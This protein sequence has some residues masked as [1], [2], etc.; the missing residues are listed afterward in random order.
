LRDGALSV[1]DRRGRMVTLEGRQLGHVMD[2]RIG[3]PVEGASTA[4]VVADTAAES[5]A[6]STALL[7]LGVEGRMQIDQVHPG[8]QAMVWA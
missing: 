5:D 7:V 1:S 8:I 4:A 3:Q 6:L 2:P